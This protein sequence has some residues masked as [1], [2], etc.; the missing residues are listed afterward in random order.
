VVVLDEATAN[1]DLVTEQRIQTLIKQEFKECTVITIAH[2]LQ[3]IIES[4][5]VLVLGEGKVMEYNTPEKLMENPESKF[6][7][8]VNELKQKQQ[9][10]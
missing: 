4:D 7:K 10:E 3:T 6:T 8:L 2:R 5:K 9:N 1:I